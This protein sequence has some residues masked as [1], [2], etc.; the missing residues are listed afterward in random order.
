M[1]HRVSDLVSDRVTP[2]APQR[3]LVFDM[4]GVLIDSEPFWRRAEIEVFGSVGIELSESDC[5]QTQGLRIDEVA[6]FWYDR[7]P[8]SGP[9]IESI[10]ERVVD[11][12]DRLI[13]TE[14]EPMA[15][16]RESIDSARSGG[17]RLGLASSS[18]MR[19]I[20]AV[21]DRLGLATAFEVVRSAEHEKRGKPHPDVY[22]ATLRE[23]GLEGADCVAVEDSAHGVASALAAGM[24]CIAIPSAETRTD[25]RFEAAHWR[26]D[27]LEDLS[28]ALPRIATER[29]E[30]WLREQN[31]R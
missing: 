21:L 23:L 24:R 7:S 1:S 19:L 14:G 16:V 8:W 28:H 11:R 22:A 26:L 27:S 13:H 6:R 18:S 3:A 30:R 29:G 20:E 17:W 12:M 9:S 10:A 4:D 5:Y 25:P 31:T 2:S 15:G